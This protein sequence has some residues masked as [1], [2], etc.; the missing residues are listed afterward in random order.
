MRYQHAWEDVPTDQIPADNQDNLEKCIHRSLELGIN[1]IETARGYGTSEFQLG[2]ILPTLPR[3][4]MMV[5]TKVAPNKETDKFLKTFDQSMSNLRLD[6]VDLFS[7]HGINNTETLHHSLKKGGCLE[8][9]LRLR[10]QGRCR[11]IGF[12][13]HGPLP[14]LL[15]AVNS[16]LFDYIN[17]HWYYIFQRNWPVIE[18]ARRHDMGVFIISPS[19]KGG[20]LYKPSPKL[21]KLCEPVSPMIFNDLFC[22]LRPEVH[23]LSI[24]A[25]K[26]TDF[27]EHCRALEFLPQA[28]KI[29][30]E[31][32]GRIRAAM[33]EALGED[34][35]NP[36]VDSIPEW[37]GIPGEINVR[38]IVRLWSWAKGLDMV[39]FGKM[40]YNL[41]GHGDHWFPGNPAETVQEEVLF[42]KIKSHPRASRIIPILR[43]AHELMKGDP[44]ERLS[45]GD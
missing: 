32:D 2:R 40:R 30:H 16:G 44:K 26:P 5:Q 24:G 1:H 22:L 17:L 45:K 9:A 21:A 37:D 8:A 43:E 7:L 41:L 36:Y 20:M 12:S 35:F 34:W 42:E 38:E 23:T 31:I 33:Q 29:T 27:D 28:E 39:E 25:A 15:D 6:Y 18:A 19:D 11:H 3:E 13:T 4:K 10:E 14:V